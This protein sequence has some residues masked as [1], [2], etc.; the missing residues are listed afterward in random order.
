M[1]SHAWG[2][3]LFETTERLVLAVS[4]FALVIIAFVLYSYA[5]AAVA[6]DLHLIVQLVAAVDGGDAD[7]ADH[8]DGAVG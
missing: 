2:L 3:E 4:L 7:A 1:P 8:D 6:R 5:A